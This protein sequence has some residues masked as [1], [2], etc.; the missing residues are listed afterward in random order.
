MLNFRKEEKGQIH[1]KSQ[2]IETRRTANH[3][4]KPKPKPFA[5]HAEWVPK[6]KRRIHEAEEQEQISSNQ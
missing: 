3:A 6:E 2:L 1:W 5:N 4:K